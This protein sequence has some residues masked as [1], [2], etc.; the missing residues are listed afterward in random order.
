MARE[1]D[2]RR[3]LQVGAGTLAASALP[4]AARAQPLRLVPIRVQPDQIFRVTVCLRPFRAQGPRVENEIIGRRQVVHNYGH[5]GSGWSLSWGSAAEA[6]RLAMASSPQTIAVVGA[7]ALGLTAAITAQRAGAKVTIYAKERYP[8]VRSARATG[9]WTPDSRV[10]KTASVA[11]DFGDRW[12]RMARLSYQMHNAYVSLP[13]NPVEWIDMYSLP[14]R[15]PEFAG[16]PPL[17]DPGFI[18]LIDRID[19]IMPDGQSIPDGTHPFA[20][21]DVSR[22]RTLSFN[23]ADLAHQLESDFLLAGGTFV[24]MELQSPGDFS[25]IREHV[26]INCTGYGARALMQDDSLTPVRGQIAWLPPQED[27]HYGFYYQKTG[28]VGR[29]DGIVVQDFG[30]NDDFGW[31]DDN[32]Q[33][34]WEAARASVARLSGVYLP[35]A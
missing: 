11:P 18:E 29:R 34:D 8:F 6:V 23:V 9:T 5:G 30:R 35:D 21:S 12:E 7:G 33:P 31:N 24:P 19:D 15:R 27:A 20:V 22:T 2:R 32:E 25:K 4:F 1:M 10:A 26:I 14:S 16:L 17:P 13:G 3:L 28:V